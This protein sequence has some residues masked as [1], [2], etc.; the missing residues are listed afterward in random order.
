MSKYCSECGTEVPEG[1]KFCPNCGFASGAS[2]GAGNQQTSTPVTGAK[3]KDATSKMMTAIK[4]IGGS[5]VFLIVIGLIFGG[6]EEDYPSSTPVPSTT[7]TDKKIYVAPYG[8]EDSVRITI[9]PNGYA[10]FDG[11]YIDIQREQ[12]TSPSPFVYVFTYDYEVVGQGMHTTTTR[13]WLKSDGTSTLIETLDL[14]AVGTT[15]RGVWS[16]NSI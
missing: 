16:Y 14:S 12:Y 11:D 15:E 9:Y 8:L 10:V 5:L 3:T 7:S 4:V 2:G 6:V 1:S 13:L